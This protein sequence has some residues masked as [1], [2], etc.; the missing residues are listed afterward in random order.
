MTNVTSRPRVRTT[1]DSIPTYKP[2]R[3]PS[4]RAG[5][6]PAYKLSSNENPYPPLPGVLKAA[7]DAAATMNRYPDMGNTALYDAIAQRFRVP[8]TSLAAGTGSVAVLYHLLQALC[9]DGDEVVYAWRSFEAYPIAVGVTGAAAVHVPL[10]PDARHDLDAM[11]D[12]ITE[13]TRAVLVCTPNNPTGPAV[14]RD[15]LLAFVDR[16]PPDVVVVIDEAYREFVRDPEIIDG[17]EVWRGRENVCVLRTFSKAYG[18][19]GFRVG[20]AVAP[21][22][23]ADAIR[24]CALPFGVSHV[25]QQAAIAALAHETE[26]LEQ[27]EAVVGE[28]SRVHAGLREQGWNIPDAQ[29]NFVWLPLGEDA[30]A[31]AAACE[32]AGIVVRP[33]PGDGVRASLGEVE[34]NDLLLRVAADWRAA[35]A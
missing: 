14:H 15:E 11:A 22:P 12:A 30:A 21:E 4:P 6:L 19:A 34:A 13:R 35:H 9:T 3:P 1:L 24:K 2:G 5:G 29:G 31:F 18:M 25:A 23:L 27:V 28:R 17:L 32:E 7:V 20:F 10:K 26:L 33:F 16:V 8:V